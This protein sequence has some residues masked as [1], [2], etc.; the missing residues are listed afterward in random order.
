VTISDESK[1]LTYLDLDGISERRFKFNSGGITGI[2]KAGDQVK[3]TFMGKMGITMEVSSS[4]ESF[5]G[6]DLIKVIEKGSKRDKMK[7]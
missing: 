1:H 2:L 6:S 5:E 7:L 4:M 3:I